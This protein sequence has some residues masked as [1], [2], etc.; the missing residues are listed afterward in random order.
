MT[1]TS[2]CERV[3]RLS[4]RAARLAEGQLVRPWRDCCS[5]RNKNRIQQQSAVGVGWRQDRAG[6]AV[7]GGRSVKDDGPVAVEE[8]A[9]LDVPPDGAGEDLSL[10]VAA[11]FREAFG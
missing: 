5:I 8:H 4:C 10:D 7:V 1:T 11:H 6:E 9:V 2:W 3:I